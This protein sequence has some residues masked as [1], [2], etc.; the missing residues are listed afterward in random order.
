MQRGLPTKREKPASGATSLTRWLMLWL[1]LITLFRLASLGT[2]ATDLF[3]DEAQYWSWSREL[4]FGYYSKPPMIAWLIRA[5]TSVC[6]DGEACV[7]AA[8][9][10]LY[11]A[12]ATVVFLIGRRLYEERVGFLAALVFATLPGVSFSSGIISTDVPLLLAWSVAL[13]G[14][15]M[16]IQVPVWRGALVMGAGLGLGMLSKYAMILFVPCTALYLLTT[17]ERRHLVRDPRLYGALAIGALIALPNLA[18]NAA[19]QFA[20]LSHTAD[21]ANWGSSLFNPGRALE[22]FGAQFGVFGPILFAALLI[23]TWRAWRTGIAQPDRLLLYFAVPIIALFTLQG[24][25]SRAHA[26]WAATAYVA[27]SILV[28]ATML[29]DQAMRWF[30]ASMVLHV[31]AIGV[32][33]L[34]NMLAPSIAIPFVK[35]PYERMLGW[36]LMAEATRDRLRFAERGGRPYRTILTDD[37]AVTAELLYYLRDEAI[38]ITTWREGP[39]PR[40]HYELTRA[41]DAASPEPVLAVTM[42]AGLAAIREHFRIAREIGRTR[43]KAGRAAQREVYFYHLEGYKGGQSAGAAAAQ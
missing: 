6:G 42:R 5:L 16:L 19:N 33:A 41:F 7:R 22:F 40:D 23:I 10:I 32:I 17:P 26:N 28:T 20:T 15:I 14:L 11:A 25:I 12:T 8:S 18:W 34:G 38:P 24:F 37:R 2:N 30:R 43:L 27:G 39:S 3:F 4:D 35:N 36:H 21:N 31:T 13:L 29:R 1:G 9:P